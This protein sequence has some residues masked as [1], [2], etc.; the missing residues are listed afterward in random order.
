MNTMNYES[1]SSKSSHQHNKSPCHKTGTFSISLWVPE[2]T[3]SVNSRLYAIN[4]TSLH[5]YQFIP[6][7]TIHQPQPIINHSYSM[8]HNWRLRGTQPNSTKK[9][10]A[11]LSIARI[12]WITPIIMYNPTITILN[13]L[14]YIITLSS[15]YLCPAH[16]TK[17][18]VKHLPSQYLSSLLFFFN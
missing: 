1:L 8:S 5:P 3:G 13:V 17:H 4:S 12:G 7:L 18:E 2:G 16:E 14:I 6:N 11:C 15:Y 10:I 9:I